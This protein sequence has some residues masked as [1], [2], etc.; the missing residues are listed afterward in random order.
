MNQSVLTTL[1]SHT[2]PP[3]PGAS[4][5]LRAGQRQFHHPFNRHCS[6][7]RYLCFAG[8]CVSLMVALCCLLYAQHLM[9]T[10]VPITNLLD[11][12][13]TCSRTLPG[14]IR[15]NTHS[16]NLQAFQRELPDSL[17]TGTLPDLQKA[18]AVRKW[19]R[20]Q[21]T[22]GWTTNDVSSVDPNIL[23]FRQRIGVPGACNRFAYVFVG[24]LLAAGLDARLVGISSGIYNSGSSHDLVEVWISEL[25][26]WIVMDSMCNTM[27][28]VHGQPA[29][30]LEL[31]NAVQSDSVTFERNGAV[32]DPTPRMNRAYVDMFQHL[33]YC[34]TNAMFDGY[35]ISFFGSKRICFRHFVRP[36]GQLYPET[37]KQISLMLFPVAALIAVSLAGRCVWRSGIQRVRGHGVS[38]HIGK[39]SPMQRLRCPTCGSSDVRLSLRKLGYDKLPVLSHCLAFRCRVCNRRYYATSHGWSPPNRLLGIVVGL[40]VLMAIEWVALPPFVNM[41]ERFTKVHAKIT[42]D[43]GY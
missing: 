6:G 25:N 39:R 30:L 29:N 17:T 43:R 2:T 26:K 24:A 18:V 19:C 9:G 7:E 20:A 5:R 11:P 22:G 23:L 16:P 13:L 14:F 10:R 15:Q 3:D 21:Q 36:G 41:L 1:T 33:F 40:V 31:S 8:A 38:T 28:L 42:L 32:T 37:A 34:T 4:P 35:H 12:A 27:F